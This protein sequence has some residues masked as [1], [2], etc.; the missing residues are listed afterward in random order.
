[1][2]KLLYTIVGAAALATASMGSA[3]VM[4]TGSSG[5]TNPPP[6]VSNGSLISTIDF[7]QLSVGP[8]SF[9]GNFS[10][11]SD[12]NALANFTLS[13]ST[14]GTTFSAATLTGPGG[15]TPFSVLSP[16]N[17]ASLFLN[18]AAVVAG[19]A[20]SVAFTGNTNSSLTAVLTG[21][22]S[23]TP[24]RA[25]PEAATWAMMLLGFAGM[26]MV[27]R[28]RQRPVLAQLA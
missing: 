6:T 27:I 20:Y 3:A 24:T 22:V 21:N 9:S 17:P 5:L 12:V 4:I 14:T 16:V 13:S 8:G 15:T 28:R 10:F 18:N 26:G 23:V 19:Q 1:M 7:G 11:Q 25:V 2:R